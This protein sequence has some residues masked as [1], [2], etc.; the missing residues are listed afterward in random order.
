M[1]NI[2]LEGLRKITIKSQD[3]QP[4]DGDPPNIKNNGQTKLGSVTIVLVEVPG[5]TEFIY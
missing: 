4:P 2:C 5:N 3:N 1:A